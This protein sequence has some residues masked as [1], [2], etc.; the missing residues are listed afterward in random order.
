[1]TWKNRATCSPL[2]CSSFVQAVEFLPQKALE[3]ILKG[4]FLAWLM[5]ESKLYDCKNR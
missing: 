1:M 4:F 3:T 5:F 2:N